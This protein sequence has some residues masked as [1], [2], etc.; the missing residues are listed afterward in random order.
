VGS[1]PA[2]L[3]FAHFL[4]LL[5]HRVT[6][7]EPAAA[8]G[9]RLRSGPQAKHLP[10]GLL[11]AEVERLV[12]GRIEVRHQ[13]TRLEELT[14]TYDVVFGVLEGPDQLTLHVVQ[15]SQPGTE[16]AL[17]LL[18]DGHQPQST[19][20]TPL[21]VSEAI[22]Y[23]KWSALVLDSD[24]RG[25]NPADTLS[26][27]QVGGNSRIVSALSYLA[28]VTGEVVQRTEEVVTYD[29]LQLD[30]L[31]A[32]PT[33]EAARTTEALRHV[34][35]QFV[36]A[37]EVEHILQETDRCFSCGRCNHCDNCW[38]YCPDAC[39]SHAGEGYAVDYDYCKGCLVCAAVCPRRVISVIEEEKWNE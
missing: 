36:T 24:W 22:G 29:K 35:T 7:F 37:E 16:R 19:I 2:E 9:G 33:F 28:V 10:E 26:R 14:P 15:R 1:G 3:A 8:L 34:A 38:V 25:L 12:A 13:A 11:D 39:I 20:K 27:I 23:G 4:A 6:L 21:R 32:A 17:P 5:G 18:G 31:D 30:M